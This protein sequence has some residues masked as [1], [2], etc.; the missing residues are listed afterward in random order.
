ME[1]NE[2]ATQYQAAEKELLKLIEAVEGIEEG[3]L[4]ALE[5]DIY[6][7]NAERNERIWEWADYQKS[8]RDIHGHRK[9]IPY[10]G[11]FWRNADFENKLVHIGN[12]GQLIGVMENN[13]WDY[14]R[15]VM[16]E[17]E[18]DVFVDYLDKAFTLIDR[19]D[20]PQAEAVFLELWDWFQGLPLDYYPPDYSE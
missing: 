6:M 2:T 9:R 20:A 10:I 7:N 17:E 11:W 3:D 1:T 14:A 18:V 4:K 13:K 16:T 8:D 19:G 12:S 5:E 15:R